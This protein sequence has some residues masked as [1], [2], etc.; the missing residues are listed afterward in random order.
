MHTSRS[1]H[2]LHRNLSEL[3]TTDRDSSRLCSNFL[4]FSISSTRDGGDCARDGPGCGERDD[5]ALEEP[6]CS[7]RDDWSRGG[8][9]CEDQDDCVR[10]G[11]DCDDQGDCM[12]TGL[13]SGEVSVCTRRMRIGPG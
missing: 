3:V 4:Y 10:D 13:D 11:L 8:L 5:C 12:R 6:G 7:E 9:D 1:K 2:I